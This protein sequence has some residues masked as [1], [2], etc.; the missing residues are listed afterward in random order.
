MLLEGYELRLDG[1]NAASMAN[2]GE[3]LRNDSVGNKGCLVP[4]KFVFLIFF[5]LAS[6]FGAF[7][8]TRLLPVLIKNNISRITMVAFTNH[9]LDAPAWQS[10]RH[11]YRE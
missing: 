10:R 7:P 6:S 4:A 8:A 1:N 2:T 11:R 3:V 9:I 5:R